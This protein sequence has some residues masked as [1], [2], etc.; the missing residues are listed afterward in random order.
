MLQHRRYPFSADVI[1]IA[2]TIKL[3]ILRLGQAFLRISFNY[4]MSTLFCAYLPVEAFTPQRLNTE[5]PGGISEIK[6]TSVCWKLRICVHKWRK[7]GKKTGLKAKSWA[8]L[9]F[10]QGST[11]FRIRLLT[12]ATNFP[13][14]SQGHPSFPACISYYSLLTHVRLEGNM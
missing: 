12:E 5:R 7:G 2:G 10:L 14:G 8:W 9:L 11:R 4:W 3:Y 13:G 1:I 6:S